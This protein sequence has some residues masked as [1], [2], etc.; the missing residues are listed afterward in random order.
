MDRRFFML[1]IILL[2]NNMKFLYAV[3]ALVI[4]GSATAT[5]VYSI[6]Y[7]IPTWTKNTALY[8][9]QGDIDDG[10]YINFLQYL[11]E[12]EIIVVP[13]DNSAVISQ[14]D[15]QVA[16]LEAEISSLKGSITS[17]LQSAYEDGYNDG[18][19][20]SNT[21]DEAPIVQDV[22]EFTNTISQLENQI[23]SLENQIG[24]LNLEVAEVNSQIASRDS[25]IS[26]LNSEITSLENQIAN[27]SEVQEVIPEASETRNIGAVE[28]SGFSQAC[29]E[30]GCYTPTNLSA[31][32]G[33][34]IYMSNTDPTGVHTYTSGTVNGFTPSPDGT[35]DTGVL[36]SGDAFVWTPTETGEY[37]YYCMLH[38]W[39]VG[40]ITVN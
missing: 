21:V 20:A 39:M 24:S 12:K 36:M 5:T 19:Q 1:Q 10:E 14:L 2:N 30:T 18:N 23:T 34:T 9:G 3:L 6:D 4:V 35:F 8:W 37:P 40:T 17:D 16:S 28:E 26:I 11:V 38:T 7:Q 25:Q 32:V 29:V 31:N 13:S 27:M 22:S 33:D 15:N